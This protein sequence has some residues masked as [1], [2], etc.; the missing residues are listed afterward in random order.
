M[1]LEPKFAARIRHGLVENQTATPDILIVFSIFNFNFDHQS[2]STWSSIIINII[3]NTI[4]IT[5]FT[6]SWPMLA[7][8]QHLE[9]SPAWGRWWSRRSR[10]SRWS[11]WG[12]WWS[13]LLS[14]WIT[15]T[16]NL[17]RS[18]AFWSLIHHFYIHSNL[19]RHLIQQ[20]ES[21]HWRL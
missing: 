5:G 1:V 10:W 2:L 4:T 3:I 6:F 12:R 20:F 14:F 13:S 11:A 18:D 8:S 16:S 19:L 9:S 7:S 17:K 21:L 15:H